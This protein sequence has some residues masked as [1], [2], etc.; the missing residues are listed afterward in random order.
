[1]TSGFKRSLFSKPAWAAAPTPAASSDSKDNDSIFGQNNV[2]TDI[3]QAEE[4]RR[5]RHLAKAQR[6]AKDANDAGHKAKKRRVS[7]ES[8]DDGHP[9]SDAR[10]ASGPSSGVPGT[11]RQHSP[12]TSKERLSPPPEIIHQPITRSTPKKEKKLNSGLEDLPRSRHAPPSVPIATSVGAEEEQDEPVVL[13]PPRPQKKSTPVKSRPAQPVSEGESEEESEFVKE[14]KAQAR[15]QARLRQLGLERERSRTPY[16]SFTETNNVGGTSRVAST[17]ARTESPASPNQ[18]A[19]TIL[20]ETSVSQPPEDDPEIKLYIKS[21]I[22]STKDLIVKRKT[23]QPLKQVREFWCKTNSVDPK[24]AS[25]VFFTWNGTRLFD[26]TTMRGIIQKLKADHARKNR[27]F[28]QDL[29]DLYKDS[30]DQIIQDPSRG[31]IMIE[32]L[33]HDIFEQ[34][35]RD[36]E[37]R[38]RQ[39]AEGIEASDEYEGEAQGASEAAAAEEE[40]MRTS[41]R[42][43]LVARDLDPLTLNVRPH[44]SV[45]KIMQGYAVQMGLDKGATAWLVFDGERLDPE[46]TAEDVGFENEDE[47]EVHVR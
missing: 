2:Y 13:T 23:S 8:D 19:S 40:K 22:P 42:I 44:T 24:T 35:Q 17:V 46:S 28:S 11:S 39:R 47:I 10:S 41:I 15:E 18:A 7:A 27:S 43:R 30:D 36:K 4:E 14:L 45:R 37:K 26:S 3:V 29:V 31:Q 34:R 6:R 33:T 21:A 38:A 25:Q 32:A 20:R 1:M 9:E 5:R 16:D 12:K